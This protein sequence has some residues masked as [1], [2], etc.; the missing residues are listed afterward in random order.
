MISYSKLF[1]FVIWILFSISG[2]IFSSNVS[3][4]YDTT[5]DT[6][7]ELGFISVANVKQANLTLEIEN[8]TIINV[9]INDAGKGYINPPTYKVT[10]TTGTGAEL[11][12]VLGADGSIASVNIIN[13]GTN[14]VAPTIEVRKFSVLV[15]TDET[16]GGKWAVFA[17][18]GTEWLRT[19]TQAYDVNAYWQ[20]IDWYETNYNIFTPINYT[21]SSSYQL[22]GLED[23]NRWCCK[24]LQCRNRWMVITRKRR[25]SRYRRLYSK[26]QK[27]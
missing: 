10:D 5:S 14:Y 13:G 24:K 26:L 25:W 27:L 12:F 19:L 3:G 18:D 11:R 15:K 4:T 22:Y 8:G 9:L 23:K 17:W 20:Y 1:C 21:I 16:V 6:F 7:A 2:Q